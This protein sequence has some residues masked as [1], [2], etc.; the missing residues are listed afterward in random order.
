MVGLLGLPS[1]AMADSKPPPSIPI[2]IDA[3]KN[4]S[5]LAFDF[6]IPSSPAVALVGTGT[7]SLSTS[8]SLK[9]YVLT[10]PASYGG[11]KDAQAFAAD[12][13]PFLL[14]LPATI[15]TQDN[16]IDDYGLRLLDRTRVNTA[17]FLGSKGGGDP[18]KA[19]D[20]RLAV[21]LTVAIADGS[22]PL[23]TDDSEGSPAWL[24]CRD[25]FLGG[26]DEQTYDQSY[27]TLETEQAAIG[28]FVAAAG[29][30]ATAFD[31]G[32]QP[33][34]SALKSTF[35]QIGTCLD[36]VCKGHDSNDTLRR[37]L[38]LPDSTPKQ[39]S[40][41]AHIVYNDV[42]AIANVIIQSENNESLKYDTAAVK[43]LTKCVSDA[44]AYARYGTL[45]DVGGG[46][47]WDGKPGASDFK[48]IS[49]VIWTAA[50]LSPASLFG[51]KFD[52]TVSLDELKYWLIGG[53]ARASWDET[54]ATG[55]KA[56]PNISANVV[57]A[58]V[59]L[60]RYSEDTQFAGQ[61]GYVDT[62]ATNPAQRSFSK[63]G[64][65]WLVSGTVKLS[66]VLTQTI[67]SVMSVADQ[68]PVKN[69]WITVSYGSSTGTVKTL[70]DKTFFVTLSFSP[71][72]AN[73][74]GEIVAQ[75][76]G[77][78]AAPAAAAKAPGG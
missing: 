56:T 70:D 68:A 47:V 15:N 29:G 2:V 44:N 20:S 76:S 49:G 10:A 3:A 63:S 30:L 69:A 43:T 25:T 67:G 26:S 4:K 18:T 16:Y 51:P 35:E 60:E 14:L 48:K 28:P 72:P 77:A 40:D 45:F 58:W 52:A 73:L 64:M 36:K 13:A 38:A 78:G 11:A 5:L 39:A 74:F 19:Q 71:T 66:D 61:V 27:R 75:D 12:A 62:Q 41:K 59:G 22:D 6:G 33:T 42:Q 8:T 7:A 17:L 54:V 37:D 57:D 23:S 1:A 50:R 32:Q 65:R 31:V 24:H 55:N 9:P 34:A 46:A 21:G 53:S